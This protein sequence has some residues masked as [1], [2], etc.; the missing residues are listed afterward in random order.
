MQETQQTQIQSL[1]QADPL[2]KE[3]ATYSSILAGKSHGQRSL[4][5][6]RPIGRKELDTAER[7]RGLLNHHT[8]KLN[9]SSEHFYKYEHMYVQMHVITTIIRIQNIL[10]IDILP[11]P[12]KGNKIKLKTSFVLSICP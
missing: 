7:L 1:G 6:Y 11:P 5:G 2:E 4:V 10:S 8:V 9:F 3:M 12:A